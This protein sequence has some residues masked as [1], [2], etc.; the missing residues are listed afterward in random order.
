MEKSH[1]GTALHA[2]CKRTEPGV[3]SCVP[4]PPE[5]KGIVGVDGPQRPP[6]GAGVSEAQPKGRQGHVVGAGGCPALQLP[7]KGPVGG[8]GAVEGGAAQDDALQGGGADNADILRDKWG[9]LMELLLS[10]RCTAQDDALQGG[11]A[12]D[13][14]VL[15]DKWGWL[16]ELLLSGRCTAQDDALQGGRANDADIQRGQW[17]WLVG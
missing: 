1:N 13:A 8:A 9:W 10:G 16:M 3:H 15:R 6:I 5:C 4:H 11:G 2:N 7:G 17:R 14:D 12:D